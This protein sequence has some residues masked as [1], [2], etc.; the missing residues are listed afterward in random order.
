MLDKSAATNGTLI[1]VALVTGW[2][3][4]SAVATSGGFMFGLLRWRLE[5]YPTHYWCCTF[6]FQRDHSGPAPHFQPPHF[7]PGTAVLTLLLL[8][9]S[10]VCF[11]FD[12]V[13]VSTAY[14]QLLAAVPFGW[15]CLYL[16]GAV[17]DTQLPADKSTR[18]CACA[19]VCVCCAVLKLC[20]SCV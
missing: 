11:V 6:R 15:G 14:P 2:Y 13:D 7:S 20:T 9:T 5:R 3:L 1:T 10:H 18:L 16:K 8:A 19:H 17:K 4:S 12:M